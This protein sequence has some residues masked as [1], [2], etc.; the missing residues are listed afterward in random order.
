MAA[1]T[2]KMEAG[3][4]LVPT[5]VRV[6]DPMVR[7]FHWS[8]LIAFVA[9]YVSGEEW[10]K[11]HVNIGYVVA[12]LVAFRL[13]WGLI[14]SK[15]A[16]FNDFICRPSTIVAFLRDSVAMKARRYIGHNPA[17]GAMVIALLLAIIGISISGYMMGMDAFWGEQWVQNL[18]EV[19]VN[20][21]IGL[22]VLHIAGVIFA[23][24]EHKEN[25]I[26]SMFTGKKRG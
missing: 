20:L 19:L 6:W 10:E 7:V 9:A 2:T 18:H 3:G 13:V 17:G 26:K 1:E 11:L 14:G 12:G 8:L 21:T 24:F 5:T 22:V 23:S 15:H 25:L 4:H 16:R